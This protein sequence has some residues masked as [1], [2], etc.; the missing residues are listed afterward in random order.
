MWPRAAPTASN[1]AAAAIADGSRLQVQAP[2]NARPGEVPRKLE[3]GG[4]ASK[5]TE[6]PALQRSAQGLK[7]VAD[8]MVGHLA[9]KEALAVYHL[10][11]DVS[12]S[13][14]FG[15][16]TGVAGLALQVNSR[17]TDLG[18]PRAPNG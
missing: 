14:T 5:D 11:Q 1:G 15:V 8:E 3:I 7:G 4:A 12:H 9:V 17:S 2:G 16:G 18:C 6:T 13:R 10:S